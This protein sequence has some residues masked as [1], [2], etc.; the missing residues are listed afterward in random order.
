VYGKVFASIFDGSL[1]GH[2]EATAVMMALIA[3]ADKNGVVDMT[4][5]ALAARTGFPADV[6]ER[7]LAELSKPD[8]DSRSHECEGRRI[9]PI[10]PERSWGWRLVNHG[11][12]RGIKSNDERADYMRDYMAK[13]RQQTR[14]VSPA[15]RIQ[16]L[17]RDG[18]ACTSCGATDDLEIDHILPVKG[19][20]GND[21]ENLQVLCAPCN[22]AK[23]DS[24]NTAVNKCKQVSTGIT[25]TDTEADTEE[26]K[27]KIEAPKRGSRFAL[28]QLPD[29]WIEF[30]NA[31]RQDLDA[32]VMFAKFAD[33]WKAVPGAKGRKLD[34]DATWRN[35]IRSERA[36]PDWAKPKQTAEQ[37]ALG[38]IRLMEER[39]AQKRVA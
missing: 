29:A 4:P 21:P 5:K 27:K 19:G 35:F 8:P 16:I 39:D 38:A 34:W 23:R 14:D 10:D 2:F 24:V 3:L 11:K 7:G 15:L 33:Y 17:K 20:G 12:Y 1:Y 9:V 32:E 13:R 37:V 26:E 22:R 25:H 6:V 28:T 31:E 18:H 36:T 30:V